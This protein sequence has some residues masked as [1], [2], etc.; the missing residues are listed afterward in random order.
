MKEWGLKA[1]PGQSVQVPVS[2]IAGMDEAARSLGRGLSAAAEGVGELI[3]MRERVVARG[4][5]AELRDKLQEVALRAQ[6]QMQESGDPD[7]WEESWQQTVAPM[8]EPLMSDI[9]ERRREN[10]W[11]VVR[12]TLQDASLEAQRKYE[13][14][15]IARARQQWENRLNDAV[16]RGDATAACARLEEGRE[17]FVSEE[18]MEPRREALES[19]CCSASWRRRMQESPVEALTAWRAEGAERPAKEEDRRA[20]EQEMAETGLALRRRL[21]DEW[22]QAVMQGASPSPEAVQ[23]AVAAGLMEQPKNTRRVPLTPQAEADW[24][25]RA[26]EVSA[27]DDAYASLRLQVATL[28]VSLS[29]RSRL[30]SYM[31]GGRQVPREERCRLSA[32]LRNLYARGTFGSAGDTVPQQR[33]CRL[34]REG[35]RLLREQQTGTTDEWLASLHGR[36]ATWL[37]FDDHKETV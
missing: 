34:L 25:R 19:L 31:E 8:V 29:E 26:D 12:E 33:L 18:E 10:A 21:G 23:G 27:D 11:Q 28:P 6:Q 7:N 37:C 36:K 5:A 17:V 2:G 24:M 9:P 15:R 1:Y 20:L 32:A 4:E 35:Q 16:Q 3:S 14:G 22:A 13:T 30:M